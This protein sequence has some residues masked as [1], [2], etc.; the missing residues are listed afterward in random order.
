[1]HFAHVIKLIKLVMFF[2][3]HDFLLLLKNKNNDYAQKSVRV[4]KQKFA[5]RY[6]F[7]LFLVILAIF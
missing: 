2:G 1:M 6:S 5:I 4:L 7:R 3:S